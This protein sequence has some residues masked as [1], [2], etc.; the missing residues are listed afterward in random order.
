[1]P[2]TLI[3]GPANSAKAGRVLTAYRAALAREPLLVVPRFED[4][5]YYQRE[6]A[7][8]GV[9]FGGRVMGFDGLW[10][11][12]ARQTGFAAPRLGALARA[13]VLRA[14]MADADLRALAESA[15]S[16]GFATSAGRFISELEAALVEPDQLASALEGWAAANG[17]RRAMARD[18]A[19]LHRAYRALVERLGPVDAEGFARGALKRLLA[20][21]GAWAGAPVF[22]Y[23]FDDLTGLELAAIEA[24]AAEAEITVS[25]TWEDGREAFASRSRTVEALRA[26][27]DN[28]ERLPADPEHYADRSRAALHHLERQLFA[29]SGE[30]LD[31]GSAVALLEAGGE[32]AEIEL[33]AAAVLDLLRSDVAHAEIAV[34]LRSPRAS[35]SLVEQVFR[36]YGIPVAVDRPLALEH[37]ALGTGVLSLLRCA[38]GPGSLEDLVAYLR[39]SRPAREAHEIDGFEA[40]ARRGGERTAAA[41]R[42]RWEGGHAPL[43]ELDTLREALGAADTAALC[44]LLRELT[45]TLLVTGR[46]RRALRLDEHEAAAHAGV[47]ATLAELEA[48][49]RLPGLP[50]PDPGEVLEALAGLDL[51]LRR[52]SAEDAVLVTDPLAVRARRFHTVLLAGLQEGAFPRSAPPDPF[53][54]D[55]V[56][57]ALAES[58]PGLRRPG[59]RLDDERFLFYA[60]ASRPQER[61]VLSQRTSD[62]EG[63]PLVASPFVADVRALFDDRLHADRRR[64]PLGEVTW[65]VADAPTPGERERSLRAAGPPE[66]QGPISPVRAP[67][68]LAELRA[69]PPVSPGALEA[70]ASC[71]VRWLVERVLR[72]RGIDPE[73]Q[74]LT[75]GAFAHAVLERTFT[76]LRARSG[77]AQVT[78]DTLAQAQLLLDEAVADLYAEEEF[79]LAPTVGESRAQARRVQLQLRRF[80]RHEAQGAPSDFEPEHLE[81]DFGFDGDDSLPPLELGDGALEVRGRIDRVDVDRAGGRAIVR[82]YKAGKSASEHSQANWRQSGKLQVALYMLAVQR[83]L[84][85]EVAGGLYQS[86]R[87]S[88]LRGR[89]LLLDVPDVRALTETTLREVDLCDAENFAAALAE[90][91]EAAVQLAQGM[92]AGRLEP[93]PSTCGY[94]G[95]GCSYPAICRSEAA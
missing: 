80:L 63:R 59:D 5:S 66:A 3:T 54:P 52:R 68:A 45:E 31:P 87:G 82:D 76:G 33:V 49:A 32:R 58:R 43:M 23:G 12:I 65:P 35:A 81:L 95:G 18:L 28:E 53:L 71:P 94:R 7:T 25:L 26:L 9:V 22:L 37:T 61:L 39:V 17:E 10:R 74:P 48:S 13:R 88:D 19:A 57:R 83:T 1:M 29:P 44:S 62:E 16:P 89:G 78:Q 46:L 8:A 47:L 70:Y 50:S 69:R 34:V 67:G 86:L 6:L 85:Y 79:M 4:V 64:R 14:A 77:S 40:A 51:H 91:E 41:A 93:C 73:A 72:A 55:E 92:R 30:R 60:V 75:R 21:P 24:L 27:A 11:E 36:A 56:R 42:R 2:L 84:G 20:E 15:A 90:A 38:S